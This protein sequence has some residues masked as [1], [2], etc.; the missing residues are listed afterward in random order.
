MPRYVFYDLE[1]TGLDPCFSQIIQ[2]GALLTDERLEVLDELNLR[3]RLLPHI[4]PDPAALLAIGTGPRE[5]ASAPLSHPQMIRFLVEKLDEWG[6]SHFVGHNSLRFDEQFLRHAFYTTLH[7]PYFTQCGGNRRG[8]SLRLAHAVYRLAPRA[9]TVPVEDDGRPCFKLARLAE[10]NGYGGYRAHD[11]LADA[12][13]VRFLCALIRES[14]PEVWNY[15]LRLAGKREVEATVLYNNPVFVELTAS[16]TP[17][18]IPLAAFW[19]NPEIPTEVLAFDLRHDP[20]S[21]IEMSAWALRQALNDRPDQRVI[22]RLRTNAAPLV[23]SVEEAVTQ[24]LASP[25]ECALWARRAALLRNAVAFR[26]AAGHAVQDARA[27]RS[28]ELPVEAQ[29]Y[30]CLPLDSDLTLMTEFH[31]SAPVRRLELLAAL[32]DPRFRTLGRRLLALEHPELF[33]AAFHSRCAAA[34]A[35]RL[36]AD[37]PQPWLTLPVARARL[38]ALEAEA[39]AAAHTLLDDCRQEFDRIEAR[40]K[41][42]LPALPEAAE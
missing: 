14:A 4:V 26:I 19:R 27:A 10:A 20:A 42:H 32:A 37:A 7:P 33:P 21:W 36:L 18:A 35:G 29:L 1:T 28:W 24:G 3:C 17:P 23:L 40:L 2:I 5:I 31:G 25:D 16:G 34:I 8:D 11:A 15:W 12:Y 30:S 6:P 39:P 38:A 13:A 22:R 9:L 41:P